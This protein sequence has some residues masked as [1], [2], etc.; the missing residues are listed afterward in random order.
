VLQVR[1]FRDLQEGFLLAQGLSL[2]LGFTA[3][4]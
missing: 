1:V 3:A 2:Q 4:F